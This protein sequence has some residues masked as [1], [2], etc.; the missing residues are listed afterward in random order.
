MDCRY[1]HG[2]DQRLPD[3]RSAS[4]SD[5]ARSRGSHRRP[6]EAESRQHTRE[7]E[8]IVDGHIFICSSIRTISWLLQVY[9]DSVR[10]GTTVFPL[11]YG[12]QR[13]LDSVLAV[14]ERSRAACQALQASRAPELFHVPC[15]EHIRDLDAL[16]QPD[17]S[18]T[19]VRTSQVQLFSTPYSTEASWN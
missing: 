9:P 8:T 7:S 6:G 5:G 15:G 12:Q 19:H 18:A 14:R 13:R 2:S 1:Q 11:V 17:A 10:K 16:C 4:I 3:V